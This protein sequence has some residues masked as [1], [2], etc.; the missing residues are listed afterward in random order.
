M[1]RRWM[2]N[3]LRLVGSLLCWLPAVASA[4]PP[5]QKLP[6]ALLVLPFI[7][8]QGDRETRI[9]LLNL[10]GSSQT[11]Q[12]FY[13]DGFSCNEVGFVLTMTPYQPVSWLAG[14]GFSSGLSAVPPFF[15]EG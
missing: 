3:T 13:V 15:G 8:V 11:L 4:T 2:C 6:S 9:E 5:S 7:E 12:C 1:N 14:S 10:S